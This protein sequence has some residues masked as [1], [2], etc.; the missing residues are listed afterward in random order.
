M[1]QAKIACSEVQGIPGDNVAGRRSG[2]RQIRMA[3]QKAPASEGGRYKNVSLEINAAVEA[4]A[5]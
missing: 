1:R 4:K 3:L 5:G 2:T